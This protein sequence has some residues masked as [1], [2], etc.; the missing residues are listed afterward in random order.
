MLRKH[1]ALY[2]FKERKRLGSRNQRTHLTR[3][4]PTGGA[5]PERADSA[6]SSWI[7]I[8]MDH[9]REIISLVF[10]PTPPIEGSC[11]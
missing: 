6:G 8:T 10:V 4:I 5:S 1:D 2:A 9:D 11:E 7:L 3:V